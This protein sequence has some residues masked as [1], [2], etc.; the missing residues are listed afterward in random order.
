MDILYAEGITSS[1]GLSCIEF[2]F[3]SIEREVSIDGYQHDPSSRLV[4]FNAEELIGALLQFQHHIYL[5]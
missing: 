4:L 3:P 5:V 2:S 1:N